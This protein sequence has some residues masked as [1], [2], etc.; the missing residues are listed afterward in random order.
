MNAPPVALLHRQATRYVTPLREGGSLPAVIETDAGELVVVK[1]RGAGQGTRALV[2]ELVAGQIA[3]ALGLRVPALMLLQVD[4]ALGK[5][6][7]DEEIRDLLRASRGTNLAMG[8]L[9]GALN[10][11]AS[12]RE[13]VAGSEAS[14]IV[15]F[16]AYVMN[17]DRTARNPNMM[18]HADALW[19]ID[20]GASMIWH[21]DWDG[22]TTGSDRKFGFTQQHVLLPVASEISAAAEHL[23]HALDDARLAAIT[24]SIPADWLDPAKGVEPQR[25]AYAAYLR[26]RRDAAAHFVEEALRA[27]ASL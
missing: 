24:A 25:E 22:T 1:F 23:R 8:Y 15:V 27:R 12:E 11:D 4:E 18:W 20:H 19:L 2:A 14:R 3:S 6:E 5:N 7:R 13:R 9:A 26:A 21:H 16:D 10:F 17:V